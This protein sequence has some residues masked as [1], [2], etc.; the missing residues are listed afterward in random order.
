MRNDV[1]CREMRAGITGVGIRSNDDAMAA[2]DGRSHAAVDAKVRCPSAHDDAIGCELVQHGIEQRLKEGIVRTFAH[3][4]IC[5]HAVDTSADFPPGCV[6]FPRVARHSVVLHEDDSAVRRPH[7]RAQRIDAVDDAIEIMLSAVANPRLLH[8]YY[9]QHI[10]HNVQ[11]SDCDLTQ[12]RHI[13]LVSCANL[14]QYVFRD[15]WQFDCAR[16]VRQTARFAN[17]TVK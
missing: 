8:V 15:A 16:L 10:W 12:R 9:Q 7:D 5:R 17:E 2:H 1:C 14:S 11:G 3:R 13:E 4:P 6:R